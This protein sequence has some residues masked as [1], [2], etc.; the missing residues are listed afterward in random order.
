MGTIIYLPEIKHD[1]RKLVISD[2]RPGQ[3]AYGYDEFSGKT[4][5]IYVIGCNEFHKIGMTRE[6]ERRFVQLDSA[7]PYR[8]RKVATRKVP[9]AAMAYAEA[10]IHSVLADRHIKNEW[11]DV[12]EET[13]VG[14]LKQSYY[15]AKVY[16]AAC[17]RWYMAER[18]RRQQP[19]VRAKLDR[20]Y[21][22]FIK[23]TENA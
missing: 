15:R 6:F 23:R 7:S 14:L 10:W 19:E 16:D 11:F 21:A 12:D 4:G 18:E 22:A 9:L 17:E 20:E 2:F 3:Q 5:T 8:L 1:G 13:A